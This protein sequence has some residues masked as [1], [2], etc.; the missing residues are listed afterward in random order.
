MTTFC[1][2]IVLM[3]I[4]SGKGKI[5]NTKFYE[6]AIK[7]SLFV[8]LNDEVLRDGD[9]F[10][11]VASAAI[12]GLEDLDDL[13]DKLLV[14][15]F[16]ETCKSLV[17]SLEFDQSPRTEDDILAVQKMVDYMANHLNAREI[18]K[19]ELLQKVSELNK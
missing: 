9:C 12:L 5:M 18:P 10:T 2:G 3:L 13:T 4:Y 14:A 17:D 16:R 6:N 8:I 19:L 7:E 1:V 11:L 15:V